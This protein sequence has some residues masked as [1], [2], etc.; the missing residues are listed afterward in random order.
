MLQ[1]DLLEVMI[2]VIRKHFEADCFGEKDMPNLYRTA[3]NLESAREDYYIGES[4]RES[5]LETP[6]K[7][8]RRTRI[9]KMSTRE[10]I[11]LGYE[12]SC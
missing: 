3:A 11:D 5:F 12:L 6:P 8:I 9:E 2:P 7:G 4:L 1:H 10:L